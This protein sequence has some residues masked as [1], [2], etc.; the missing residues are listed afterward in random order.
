MKTTSLVE[1]IRDAVSTRTRLQ[2][3]AHDC[4]LEAQRLKGRKS[5]PKEWA[6]SSAV[7]SPQRGS[8]RGPNSSKVS[9]I[10]STQGGL[11][12]HYNI[13]NCGLSCSH[14]GQDPVPRNLCRPLHVRVYRIKTDVHKQINTGHDVVSWASRRHH[15]YRWET[16]E[17]AYHERPTKRTH[18]KIILISSSGACSHTHTHR[19]KFRP[20]LQVNLG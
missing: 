18:H 20:S 1:A 19:F 11:S 15:H 17:E 5:R 13:A 8:V 10:F 14:W 4:S 12:W 9:T 7:S 6:G 2:G 3:R 16:V